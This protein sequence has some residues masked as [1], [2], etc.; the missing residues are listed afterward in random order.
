MHEQ[1]MK[2]SDTKVQKIINVFE[3]SKLQTMAKKYNELIAKTARLA[4]PE[5]QLKKLIF[6]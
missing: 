6:C 3:I 4:F 2:H 1:L 5:N